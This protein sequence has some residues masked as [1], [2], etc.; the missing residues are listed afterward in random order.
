MVTCQ[1][2]QKAH[3]SLTRP[4]SSTRSFQVQTCST[5][6]H[7]GDP[8]FLLEIPHYCPSK[9]ALG[10]VQSVLSSP[11]CS[12]PVHAPPCYWACPVMH[13]PAFLH[14]YVYC[15]VFICSMTLGTGRAI[16]CMYPWP[17]WPLE[18]PQL[19]GIQRQP[20]SFRKPE[21]HL[22][23]IPNIDGGDMPWP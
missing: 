9:P 8:V 5:M 23:W 19:A 1:E 22:K 14:N 20:H 18:T 16:H 15:T 21:S 7:P 10:P 17:H 2:M 4:L 3:C 11:C 12:S 13:W 6:H